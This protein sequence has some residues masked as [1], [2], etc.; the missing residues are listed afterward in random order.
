A[1]EDTDVVIARSSLLAFVSDPESDAVQLAL[2]GAVHGRVWIGLD[3]DIRFR[4]DAD[5]NG[6]AAFDYTVTDG[7]GGAPTARVAVLVKAVNDAPVAA[8]AFADV[9]VLEDEPISVAIPTG[10]L[11][12]RDGDALAL[13]V[14]Q[15][16]GEALPAWLSFAEG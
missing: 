11:A 7:N 13:V 3:G 10:L 14:R 5:F 1:A 9:V 12:D 2:G 6:E 4:P 16:S 8:A 15:A